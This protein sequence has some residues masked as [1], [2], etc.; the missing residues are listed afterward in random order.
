MMRSF[1]RGIN[2]VL[3]HRRLNEYTSYS[4]VYS[5][6]TWML[7][8]DKRS[9]ITWTSYSLLSCRHTKIGIVS[10]SK[11]NPRYLRNLKFLIKR[12]KTLNTVLSYEIPAPPPLI[13]LFQN[14][15]PSFWKCICEC[16]VRFNVVKLLENTNARKTWSWFGL[17]RC[18]ILE[19][20]AVTIRSWR[21]GSHARSPIPPQGFF[22]GL[23]EDWK[24]TLLENGKAI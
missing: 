24:F 12:T 21:T 13:P 10:N 6:Y 1:P 16:I 17:F 3:I 9:S 22:K 18:F 20:S 5:L 19:H 7:L 11:M 15:F 14:Y 8:D 4:S 2:N 23:P